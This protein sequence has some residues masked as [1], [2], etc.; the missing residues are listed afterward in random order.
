MKPRSSRMLSRP[1][2]S[3]VFMQ[4]EIEA[5]PQPSGVDEPGGS[6]DATYVHKRTVQNSEHVSD[7]LPLRSFLLERPLGQSQT[8]A[9]LDTT[10]PSAHVHHA[11]HV[12][13]ASHAHHTLHTH[14]HSL[15]SH[16][17]FDNAVDEYESPCELQRL[18]QHSHV[19]FQAG[20]I[21]SVHNVEQT[22]DH[23]CDFATRGNFSS[24]LML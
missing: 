20:Q 19:R 9:C 13:H 16:E 18:C 24:V 11:P 17:P 7:K 1:T 5:E 3:S 4:E 8:A 14:N 12:H 10:E 2:A 6:G 15:R 22:D 23:V 21:H